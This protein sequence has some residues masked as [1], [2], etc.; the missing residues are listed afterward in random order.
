MGSVAMLGEA[1]ALT[2]ALCWSVSLVLFQRSAAVSPLAM[3][4]F[5]NVVATVLLGATLA[6]LGHGFDS[7]RP[8]GDWLRLVA[9]GVLGIAIADT[10]IFMALRRLGAGLLAVVDCA[11]APTIVCLSALFLGERIGVQLG[12]GAALVS[13]GVLAAAFDKTRGPATGRLPAVKTGGDVASGV[14][15]GITGIVAMGVGVVLAKKVLERSDLVEVTT[16]RMTAGVAAQLAWLALVP[17]QRGAFAVF[18]PSAAWRTLVPAAVLSSYVSMLLWLGGFK[19]APASRAAVLNQLTTV[20][21]IVLARMFLGD[22]LTAR[23]AV[24]AASAIAG[25]LLVVLSRA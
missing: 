20:F 5:K 4:L 1:C 11:Y 12:V 2:A 7:A 3:N 19:W 18:R 6:A 16:I 8:L 13:A 24:G 9:S 15:L 23:R 10:L 17:A 25:A 21:T 14:A 22:A